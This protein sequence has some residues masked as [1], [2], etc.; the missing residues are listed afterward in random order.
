MCKI[1]TYLNENNIAFAVLKGVHDKDSYQMETK[2]FK[3]DLDIVLDCERNF[4]IN[5]LKTHPSFTYLEQNSFLDIENNLRIDFYFQTINVGYYHYLKIYE[6][7]F[8]NKEVSEK[9]YIVYQILDP[10][11]KFSKYHFR[12]QYRLSAYFK[13][14]ISSE[15]KEM[16]KDIIGRK[17]GNQLVDNI[18]NGNFDISNSFIK[19]C[20]WKM[21][22]INGNFVKMLQ[23]RIL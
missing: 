1:I 10:L 4:F 13:L 14:D 15:I 11:L 6:Q 8:L 20:K 21:L 12:H 17:L 19:K 2:E 23:S 7:S 5:A 3:A 22:F 18:A 9:E 16:L